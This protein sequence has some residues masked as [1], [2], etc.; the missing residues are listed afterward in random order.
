MLKSL[1]QFIRALLEPSSDILYIGGSD[2]LPPP[3]SPATR[4]SGRMVLRSMPVS[5]LNF[6][7]ISS[8]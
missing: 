8:S 1:T 3:L 7:S 4:T 5:A 6:C 2:I